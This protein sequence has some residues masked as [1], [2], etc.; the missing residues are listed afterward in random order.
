M[1]LLYKEKKG[2]QMS[3]NFTISIS[4][5]E[6]NFVNTLVNK[7]HNQINIIHDN[8]NDTIQLQIQK[9]VD[10]S[11]LA[12]TL[13]DFLHNFDDSNN[14]KLAPAWFFDENNSKMHGPEQVFT[15]TP[16]EVL[17]I[18]ILLKNNKIITYSKMIEIL[19]ENEKVSQNAL[20]VF[21]KDIRK[22]LPP[23][24]LKNVQGIGY[25]LVLYDF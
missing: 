16:K 20:R 13:D 11:F 15:L 3:E 1:I 23:N 21:T 14:K 7:Y 5:I 12:S 25:N 9:P 4:G 19:W 22:K 6:S 17:F 24:T 8:N 2:L 18:K 10:E